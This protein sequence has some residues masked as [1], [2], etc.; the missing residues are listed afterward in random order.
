MRTEYIY[1]I[2]EMVNEIENVDFL[3][4]VYTIVH[5]HVRKK[6]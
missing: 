2:I 3:R 1:L 6:G 5:H 4:K